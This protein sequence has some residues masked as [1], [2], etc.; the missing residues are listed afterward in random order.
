VD[1]DPVFGGNDAFK[2]DFANGARVSDWDAHGRDS[3]YVAAVV[4]SRSAATILDFL[5]AT[6]ADAT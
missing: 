4:M 1:L 2:M 3:Y 5:L 6:G